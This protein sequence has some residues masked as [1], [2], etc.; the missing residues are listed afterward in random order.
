VQDAIRGAFV[1]GPGDDDVCVGFNLKQRHGKLLLHEKR[2]A[3]RTSASNGRRLI[4]L[5]PD[6]A[7][8]FSTTVAAV[9]GIVPRG[10]PPD[11]QA[12]AAAIR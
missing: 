2:D 1:G 4:R 3:R 12:I 11:W 7:A 6:P 8:I 5:P 10:R 9:A